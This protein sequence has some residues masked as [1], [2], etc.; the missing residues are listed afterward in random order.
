MLNE[1]VVGEQFFGRTEVLSLLQKR[2]DALKDGY[3]Q[4][5]ALTGQSL[6]GKSSILHNLLYNLKDEKI[7]PVYIEV[8]EEPFANFSRKFM[9][10]LLYNFLKGIGQPVKEDLEFL[11]N[12]A[13][14]YTPNTAAAIEKIIDPSR[15]ISRE[16]AYSELFD[17]TSFIKEETHKSCIIIFD[18]FHNL[19]A[20]GL[21]NPFSTF[22]KKIMVQKDTMYVVTSSKVSSVKKILSEKLSLLF[23]NFESIELCGF[24][25][26][27]ARDFLDKRLKS[28]RV[29]EE[30]K[31]FLVSFTDANPFY[32]DVMSF[33]LKQLADRFAFKRITEETL[34]QAFQDVFFDFKGTVNQ[35]LSNYIETVL[36]K[37]KGFESYYAILLALASGK[38][39]LADIANF[40]RKRRA[41]VAGYLSSL[42]E[43][44][45]VIKTGPFYVLSDHMLGFWLKNVY[46]KK[47]SSIISYMPERAR[48]F[49][50][51]MR[52]VINDFLAES[53][54]DLVE[55]V[56]DILRLFGNETAEIGH[57]KYALPALTDVRLDEFPRGRQHIKAAAKDKTWIVYIKDGELKDIDVIEFSEQCKA[58]KTPSLRKVIVAPSGAEINANLLAM[59]EKIWVWGLDTLNFLMSVYGK[60]KITTFFLRTRKKP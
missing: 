1:P 10:S 5:I 28:I 60:P 54:K 13:R 4:N 58:L 11:I 46:Q 34:I 39:R 56:K 32:L 44:D 43:L 27:S 36:S 16:E 15:K 33:R 19:A 23:G 7:I 53:K 38:N 42:T 31:E 50:E 47:R 12:E 20:L 37:K 57:K 24:D 8:L 45:I 30:Y 18:E 49:R 17:L 59:E 3:R 9:G 41:D 21:K 55:K 29:P 22:G 25:L 6:T 52:E 40:V 14:Q 51:R 2:I 48:D 26:N 35:Y